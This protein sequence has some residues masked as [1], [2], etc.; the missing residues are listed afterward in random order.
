MDAETMAYDC[1]A[2]A[3]EDET[4]IETAIY[5]ATD[6][7]AEQIERAAQHGKPLQANFGGYVFWLEKF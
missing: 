1:L 3:I 6:A 5:T 4:D 7:L 2:A